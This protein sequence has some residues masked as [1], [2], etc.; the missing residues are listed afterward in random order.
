MSEA[1]LVVITRCM[2]MPEEVPATAAA[3]VKKA[4]PKKKGAAKSKGS[5]KDIWSQILETNKQQST[6]HP[7]C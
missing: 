5:M 1:A 4:P 2:S 6:G 3:P 7:P